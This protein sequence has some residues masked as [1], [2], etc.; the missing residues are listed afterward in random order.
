MCASYFNQIFREEKSVG[1]LGS[2]SV[3]SQ[4][5]TSARLTIAMEHL[6][7]FYKEVF[8]KRVIAIDEMRNRDFEPELKS[9][10]AE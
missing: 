2:I 7:Y 9:Q 3:N 1:V 8:L 4:T 10:S 6:V 5:E